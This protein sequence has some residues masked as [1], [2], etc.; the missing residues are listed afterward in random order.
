MLAV[1]AIICFA[2]AFILKLLAVS[3]G[4]VDLVVLLVIAGLG[5]IAAHLA[6]PVVRRP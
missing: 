5:F 3:T 2:V 6:W 4:S 1:I